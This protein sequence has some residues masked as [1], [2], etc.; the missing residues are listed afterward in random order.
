MCEFLRNYDILF[1]LTYYKA[2]GG[3]GDILWEKR[4]LWAE[5]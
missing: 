4:F 5:K 1:L 2:A 3:G